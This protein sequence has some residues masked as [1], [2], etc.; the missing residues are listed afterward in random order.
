MVIDRLEPLW[1]EIEEGL[2]VLAGNEGAWRVLGSEQTRPLS[3]G[4]QREPG[5]F[6]IPGPAGFP[7][8]GLFVT[9]DAAHQDGSDVTAAD[10]ER[11][12]QQAMDE[13][14]S[15]EHDSW[16]TGTIPTLY[17]IAC[18]DVWEP[19]AQSMAQGVEELSSVTTWLSGQ[20]SGEAGWT[21]PGR[22]HAPGWLTDLEK[23]WPRTSQSSDTF[24]EFWTD[25]N[26]KVGHYLTMAARLTATSAQV[27]ATV[28]DFQVNLVEATEKAR[29]RVREAMHQWQLWESD[30]GAWPTGDVNDNSGAEALLNHISF[31]AG[32][33][34]VVSAST[35]IGAPVAAVAGWVSVVSGGLTYA[36]PA[37]SID[38]A[39]IRA[40]TASDLHNA[41]MDDLRT[42][43]D[44]MVAVLDHI[45]TTPPE[46]G[47]NFAGQALPG[48][49]EMASES[50][51]D[52]APLP[53]TI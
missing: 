16:T 23:H 15:S 9:L 20:V 41:Y 6:T 39:I 43:R 50:R 28:H 27:A 45:Q 17:R 40:K 47:S 42:I 36:I 49:V 46:D 31:G 34:G 52:W 25:V 32:V 8:R 48:F 13:V 22:E 26:D 51:E 44:N 21:S 2:G 14:W 37:T 24:F 33:V 38:M 29:D 3:E 19:D 11:L 7:T 1:T 5:W 4:W 10:R 53:V 12:V 30:S 35:V 18:Q